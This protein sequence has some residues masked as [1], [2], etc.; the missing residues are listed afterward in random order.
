MI[1]AKQ[2]E[3]DVSFMAQWN[4]HIATNAN[5][6][7]LSSLLERE[8]GRNGWHKVKMIPHK[9]VHVNLDA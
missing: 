9:L 4:I 6:V 8:R 1:S 5:L 2:T 3:V 7:T